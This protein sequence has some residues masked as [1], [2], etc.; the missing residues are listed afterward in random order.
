MKKNLTFLLLLFVLLETICHVFGIIHWNKAGTS[1]VYFSSGIFIAL[2]PLIKT[3]FSPAVRQSYSLAVQ[4]SRN[5]LHAYASIV[6]FVIFLVG[7]S[8]YSWQHASVIF[9]NHPIDYKIADMLP[10]IQIMCERLA[11]R[12]SIYEILPFWSGMEPIYLP[13]MWLPYFPLHYFGMDIRWT[14]VLL[15]LVSLFFLF[16]ISR[17][18]TYSIT[19]I[20]IL[21]PLW[22]LFEG[23]FQQDSRLLSLSEEPVVIAYYLF[24]AFALARKNY[25]MIG[26]AI[27]LCL[28][29]RF[30]LAIWFLMYLLYV[31]VFQS[32]KGAVQI[33]GTVMLV[34]GLLLI[35]TGAFRQLEVI[36]GLPEVYIKAVMESR[37]KFEGPVNENL[38]LAK[39]FDY[40]SLALVHQIFLLGNYIIP[41]LC[42]FLFWKLK[43][44]INQPFFAICSL[45][46]SLVFFYNFLIIPVLYLFYTSTFLSIAILSWYLKEEG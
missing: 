8:Y 11:S 38:G 42:L 35:P 5:S 2:L 41:F 17:R 28:M 24:L 30:S 39:F 3:R 15:L 45:K 43:S 20:V 29:S 46:L 1:I 18:N 21:L 22:I 40:D 32:K 36:L 13:A 44:V 19:T 31:F 12:Q 14:G 34:S 25:W 4:Q 33:A 9:A 23:I 7:L 10:V 6:I 27:G 26:V 16:F 37:W